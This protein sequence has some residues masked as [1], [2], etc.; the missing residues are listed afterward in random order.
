MGFDQRAHDPKEAFA[1]GHGAGDDRG[2]EHVA[3]VVGDHSRLMCAIE[4]TAHNRERKPAL[5]DRR[6]RAAMTPLWMRM[7]AAAL[8]APF[9]NKA[10][11][12]ASNIAV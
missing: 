10:A 12:A 5:D 9:A 4:R 3:A 6:P 7:A 2:F 8:A 11:R 1:F